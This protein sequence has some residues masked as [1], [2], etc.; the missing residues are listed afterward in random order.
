[1]LATTIL[2]DDALMCIALNDAFTLGVLSSRAHL[3]WVTAN[4]ASMGV[5][6]GDVRYIK[7]RCFDRFPFPATGDLQKQPIRDLTEKL[8][9]HRRRVLEEHPGLSLTGLY[10]VVEELREGTDPDA[11]DPTDRQNFDDGQVLILKELH[12]KLDAEVAAAYGWPADLAAQEIL[13]RLVSL[14]KERAAEEAKGEVRWLRPDYQIPR[15]GTPK[16][17]AELDLLGGDMRA[18]APATKESYPADEIAQTAAV[19]AVLASAAEPLGSDAIAA[20]FKQGRKCVRNVQAVLAS[21]ARMGRVDTRDS[22]KSFL[23]RPTT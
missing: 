3:C 15:F 8:D 23:L 1:M 2:P 12:D 18:A 22:G 7:S 20:T 19:M 13:G 11:L 14:N 16:Q 6:V 5:Y 4:A 17:K 10:N 21:L 9:T